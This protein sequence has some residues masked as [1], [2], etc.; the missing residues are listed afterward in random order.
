M[1]GCDCRGPNGRL[2]TKIDQFDLC[3]ISMSFASYDIKC[4][5]MTNDAYDI[6]IRHKSNW[7]ILV[8]K[9]PSGPQQ[10]HLF[11]RFELTNCLDIKKLKN[12]L[13]IFSFINFENPLYFRPTSKSI[14]T[15]KNLILLPNTSEAKFFHF[16]ENLIVP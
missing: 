9:R 12:A 15:Y 11:I 10:S 5:I 13:E 14:F 16:I 7:S 3:H 6:E 2:A 4:H 1:N 8:F